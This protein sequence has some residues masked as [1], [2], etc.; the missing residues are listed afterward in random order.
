MGFYATTKDIA[1][2]NDME[3]VALLADQSLRLEVVAL[4]T[5][6]H[7]AGQDLVPTLIYS[8]LITS[9]GVY[10]QIAYV[11]NVATNP[12]PGGQ[13]FE[14]ALLMLPGF[15]ESTGSDHAL[16]FNQ[17]GDSESGRLA[18][19]P[20]RRSMRYPQCFARIVR[21]TN[22]DFTGLHIDEFR[23]HFPAPYQNCIKLNRRR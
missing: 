14:L 20:H 17:I 8:A 21:D 9:R 5:L 4:E 22:G 10:E 23:W 18:G 13:T 19:D 11:R 7:P 12:G 3:G 15:E 6:Q 1:T 16:C 2:G